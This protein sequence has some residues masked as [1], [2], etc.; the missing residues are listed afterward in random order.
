MFGSV[1]DD[2]IFKAAGFEL[3]DRAWRKCG[4]PGTISYEPGAIMERGDFN[5]D[6]LVDALVTEGG[7]DCFRVTGYGYTLV[8]QRRD[9]HAASAVRIKLGAK[10]HQAVACPVINSMN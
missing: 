2:E 8:S 6:G 4:D 1:P 3:S 9:E 10:Q 7:T 5:G